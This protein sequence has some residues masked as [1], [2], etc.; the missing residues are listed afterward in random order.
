VWRPA[1]CA[2]RLLQTPNSCWPFADC[3][4][5]SVLCC[6]VLCCAV[7][8]A[9]GVLCVEDTEL[10]FSRN[11]PTDSQKCVCWCRWWRHVSSSVMRCLGASSAVDVVNMLL[12]GGE[13][14]KRSELQTGGVL[15]SLSR[16]YSRSV[17]SAF[18]KVG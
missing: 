13:P 17:N 1:S 18:L 5:L 4:L 10:A 14:I 12:L 8:A 2:A 15:Q 11:N 6:A 16:Q 9:G 3:R 7:C